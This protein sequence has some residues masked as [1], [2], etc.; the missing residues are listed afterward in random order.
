MALTRY[1]GTAT[2]STTEYSL[3]KN[4]A[5]AAGSP[6]TDDG[7]MQAVID[8]SAVALGDEYRLRVYEK[9]EAS[10]TQRISYEA[11]F[12][13]PQSMPTLMT[14][15]FIVA[16]AWDVTLTKIAGTDRAIRWSIRV[17]PV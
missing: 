16:E 1:D 10:G 8:L 9:T 6:M 15:A 2:I 3:P 17:A 14:P 7:V 11:T 4:A 13:G 12:V 5:Y